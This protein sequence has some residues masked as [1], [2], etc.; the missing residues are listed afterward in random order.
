MTLRETDR[1]LFN[2]GD[3]LE[4]DSAMIEDLKRRARTAPTRRFR[5]CLHQSPDET[6]QE[7][8]I[9]HCRDNY[10]RPH[11]HTT[12]SSCLIL[13]GTL[14]VFVFDDAGKVTSRIDLAPRASG[15]PFTLRLGAGVWHMPVCRSEQ[16]VFY[17]TM[18]GPFQRESA[19]DWAPWSPEE[20]DVEGIVGYLRGL[21]V[22]WSP[23]RAAPG[24]RSNP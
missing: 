7:M 24:E 20:D 10:S 8:L 14:S 22:D 3:V 6:V 2:T 19:N 17:E 12:P 15:K 1:A 13:E 5:L 21:G 4:V 11:R 18:T 23:P 16:L 9:V